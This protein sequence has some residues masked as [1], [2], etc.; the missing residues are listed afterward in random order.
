MGRL[1]FVPI[2][3]LALAMP[4]PE[5]LYGKIALQLQNLAAMISTKILVLFGQEVTV[6]AS[7]M[8]VT[9]VS[10]KTYPL[11]VAEACSGMRSLMAFFALGVAMAYVE[12]RPL[13]QR[14]TII[15]AGIPIA[16]VVNILRV[17]ATSTM[18]IIDQPELG[19]DFMHTAMGM[20]LLIP[21]LLLL[22]LLTRFLD[23]LYVEEDEED[24]EQPPEPSPEEEGNPSAATEENA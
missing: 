24:E 4:W 8:Q 23:K 7:N 11:T 17:T 5:A 20:V 6:S 21:A 13:W 1:T 10:G 14:L 16:I 9:S 15:L 3:F 18:Y 22:F 19:Q 2:F 12:E